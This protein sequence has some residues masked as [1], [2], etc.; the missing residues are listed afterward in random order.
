MSAE[1]QSRG[2]PIVFDDG[3]WVY[4]DTGV[5]VDVSRP[6]GKCGKVPGDGGLDP[7]LMPL[8]AALTAAGLRT[9]ASCC[10][11][12][13]RPA[14]I[15]LEDGREI[16]IARSREEARKMNSGIGVDINGGAK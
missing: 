10:G 2:Y 15:I 9:I 16:I 4:A 11:H 1:L 5:M 3:T 6:C 13:F 7:C 12:G 8:I 14:N